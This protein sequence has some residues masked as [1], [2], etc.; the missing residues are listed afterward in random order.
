MTSRNT[1]TRIALERLRLTW[2]RSISRIR[3][4]MVEPRSL[5]ISRSASQ[6]ASST[7]AEVLRPLSSTKVRRRTAMSTG[8]TVRGLFQQVRMIT[9]AHEVEHDPVSPF[10]IRK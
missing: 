5:A 4:A 9:G 1:Q 8:H 10:G 2:L 7:V 6:N 3:S